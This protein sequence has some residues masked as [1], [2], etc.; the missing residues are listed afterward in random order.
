MDNYNEITVGYWS[1]KGLGSATRQMVIYSGTPLKAKIYKLLTISNNNN[2]DFDGSSWH[3]NDKKILKK[4]NSL[5]NLPYIDLK[6]KNNND[7]LISQS[8]A[9]LSYLGRK[10]NMF[11]SNNSEMSQCEQLLNETVDLRNLITSF[12]Y[13]HFSDQKEENNQAN[14]VFKKAFENSNLGKIQKF[15]CWIKLNKNTDNFFLVNNK[16]SAADFN[17]FDVLDFYFEFIKHYSFAKNTDFDKIL[18]E[19]GFPFLSKFYLNFKK[20]PQMKKYFNS[21]LYK[22][23]YTNKSANFGSGINGNSWD[24]QIQIDETPDEILIK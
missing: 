12:A 17:L 16:I 21:I 6:D 19:L 20:L 2:L 3:D 8:N 9:C 23:P 14:E 1:T 13:T 15:E 5:I 11:G 18:I 10:F 22:L 4:R 24:F 7:I